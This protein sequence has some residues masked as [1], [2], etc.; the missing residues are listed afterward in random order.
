MSLP[1]APVTSSFMK[2]L[3]VAQSS[4]RASVAFAPFS[5]QSFMFHSLSNALKMKIEIDGVS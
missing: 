2:Y 1:V 4:I 5:N 3:A